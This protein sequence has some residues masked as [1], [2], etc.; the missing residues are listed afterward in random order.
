M[1]EYLCEV[2]IYDTCGY[3][4]Q[5]SLIELTKNNKESQKKSNTTGGS[6]YVPHGNRTIR[7]KS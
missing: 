7:I 6:S 3:L 4:V 2:W 5:T 1:H